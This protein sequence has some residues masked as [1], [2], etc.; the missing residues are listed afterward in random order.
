MKLSFRYLTLTIALA[1]ATSMGN[2]Q[3][4]TLTVESDLVVTGSVE[5]GS[6]SAFGRFVVINDTSNTIGGITAPAFGN[7]F[8]YVAIANSADELGIDP[9]Q[10]VANIGSNFNIWNANASG[11]IVFRM[12]GSDI[13]GDAVFFS[14]NGRIGA[15]V[16]NPLEKFHIGGAILLG[17]TTNSNQG[18]L[19]FTGTDFEGYKNAT[20]G[21]VSLTSGGSGG[22]AESA[23]SLV[24]P[25]TSDV[26]LSVDASGKVLLAE[27]QGDIPMFGQ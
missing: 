8:L 12:G 2:L 14:C 13:D 3:A 19:R 21:W 16:S 20:D 6:A 5:A 22:T 15:G 23:S 27:A 1:Y 7:S 4:E 26:K 24:V 17:N 9:N 11:G 25:G 10:I 18:A